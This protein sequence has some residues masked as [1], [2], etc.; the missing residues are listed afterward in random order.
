MA[1]IDISSAYRSI[2]ILPSQ[3][4]YQGVRW[5]IDGSPE[6]LFDVRVC[7]GAGNSPYFLFYFIFLKH[8]YLC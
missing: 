6:R 7:F 5:I 2:S 3:W 8:L 1:S 4:K